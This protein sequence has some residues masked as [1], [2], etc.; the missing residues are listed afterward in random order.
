MTHGLNGPNLERPLLRRAWYRNAS[1]QTWFRRR[2]L[3]SAFEH[4]S[5]M[6]YPPDVV[7]TPPPSPESIRKEKWAWAPPRLEDAQEEEV[8][9]EPPLDDQLEWIGAESQLVGTEGNERQRGDG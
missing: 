2:P 3:S 5:E 7:Y 8:D 4:P 6:V 1:C 9:G